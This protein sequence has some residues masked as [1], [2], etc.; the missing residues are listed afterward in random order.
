MRAYPLAI[1]PGIQ[2]QCIMLV[3]AISLTSLWYMVRK[4]EHAKQ[5]FQ[6]ME[7]L[8]T[9]HAKQTNV[10]LEHAM[11]KHAKQRHAKQDRAK[12]EHAK[13]DS[14]SIKFRT[15]ECTCYWLKSVSEQL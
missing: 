12:Q 7:L 13:Q 5:D 14:Q 15:A 4:Q 2:P 10:N 11:Q 9:A 6:S 1:P 8:R 3:P